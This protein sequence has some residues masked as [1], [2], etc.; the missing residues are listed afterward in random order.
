MPDSAM[1]LPSPFS[2]TAS[3][4]ARAFSATES[5]W[6]EGRRPSTT[7]RVCTGISVVLSVV[8]PPGSW[9]WTLIIAF[10]GRVVSA[11]SPTVAMAMRDA[12]RVGLRHVH[13]DADI[14]ERVV[15]AAELPS[16]RNPRTDRCR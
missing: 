5:Y 6:N 4:F 13:R 15:D 1:R 14:G 7:S 10:S 9:I 2:A 8:R 12:G 11:S 16:L 3:K